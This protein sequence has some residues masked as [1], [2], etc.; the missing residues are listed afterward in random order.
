MRKF[1]IGAWIIFLLGFLYFFVPLIGTLD[2]SLRL[3]KDHITL[4][5]YRNVITSVRF[6]NTF[7]YCDRRN[8]DNKL[9]K[10]IASE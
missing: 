2:F 8:D 3:V 7:T 10:S 5:A 9:P 6:Q 1:P 4:E